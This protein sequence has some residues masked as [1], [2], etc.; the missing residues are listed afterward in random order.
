MRFTQRILSTSAN[1]LQRLKDKIKLLLSFPCLAPILFYFPFCHRL[2]PYSNIPVWNTTSP[3]PLPLPLLNTRTSASH[4]S[5][6]QLSP[7]WALTNLFPPKLYWQLKCVTQLQHSLKYQIS[8][9]SCATL[10][11]TATISSPV[12]YGCLFLFWR[13]SNFTH[14]CTV[15][16]IYLISLILEFL[17]G[18]S[19]SISPQLSRRLTP[20]CGSWRCYVSVKQGHQH[21][22]SFKATKTEF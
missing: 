6:T 2:S 13:S 19:T 8:T 20:E 12:K 18:Q 4:A 1:N 10:T 16:H 22:T 17:K 14:S 5:C 9:N 7:T 15:S 3:V 21:W 11:S